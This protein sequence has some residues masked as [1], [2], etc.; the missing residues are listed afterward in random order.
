MRM[1]QKKV[2]FFININIKGY[3]LNFKSPI[4]M[5]N[6]YGCIKIENVNISLK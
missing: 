2:Q 4:L 3:D 6:I 1:I 5:N